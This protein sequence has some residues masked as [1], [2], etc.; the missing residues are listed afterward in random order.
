MSSL[1]VVRD[2]RPISSSFDAESTQCALTPQ[3]QASS[4]SP[5]LLIPYDIIDCCSRCGVMAL[6]RSPFRVLLVRKICPSQVRRQTIDSQGRYS[7]RPSSFP[8]ETW[9]LHILHQRHP[10]LPKPPSSDLCK[11][12]HRWRLQRLVDDICEWATRWR[13][14]ISAIKCVVICFSRK[15]NPPVTNIVVGATE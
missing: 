12:H 4:T 8:I 14:S 6:T 11:R 1:V 2:C 9:A 5:L 7:W 3:A 13:R 10:T 15:R